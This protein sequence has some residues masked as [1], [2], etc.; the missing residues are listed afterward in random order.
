MTTLIA[1]QP[2][3]SNPPFAVPVTLDNATYNLT[4]RWNL[5][6]TGWYYQL[7]DQNQNVVINAALVGSPIG[8]NIY[9]AP[10]LFTTST[11]LYR[12]DTGNFE[13][14]P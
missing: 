4:C 7:I 13:V 3:T 12:A 6:R 2:T 5:Y 14:S 9:L 8:Y 11:L 10:G 1:F